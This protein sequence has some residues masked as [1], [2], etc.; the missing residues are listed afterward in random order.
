MQVVGGVNK[1]SCHW[2]DVCV[3]PA[4]HPRTANGL[5]DAST[6]ET[7]ILGW[8][9]SFRNMNLGIR[10]GIV[11][12]VV[13]VDLESKTGG[14]GYDSLTAITHREPSGDRDADILAIWPGP[15]VRTGNG[16][17]L[18]LKPLHTANR[19]KMMPGVDYRGD[20]GYIVA[21][22]SIHLN[23]T[24]YEWL[25]KGPMPEST[26]LP[27]WLWLLLNPPTCPY[28][29]QR[30]RSTKVCKGIASHEHGEPTDLDGYFRWTSGVD[31]M[32]G[33]AG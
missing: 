21:P 9:K 24:R 30:P 4:K 23:G 18:F 16:W 31:L 28:I 15:V 29:I 10:T 7:V 1:C 2:R 17:H 12:D 27:V 8:L 13:D 25:R 14:S 22:P 3:S 33:G 32:I 5:Y 11:C 6:D 20:G 19:A 26:D